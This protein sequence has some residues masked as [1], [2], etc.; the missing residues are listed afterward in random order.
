MASMG[1]SGGAPEVGA[2]C[3]YAGRPMTV[4]GT[5]GSNNTV[6]GGPAIFVLENPPAGASTVELTPGNTTTATLGGSVSVTGGGVLRGLT[7]AFGT[8][9]PASV[10]VP[11]CTVGGMVIDAVCNGATASAFTATG[12]GQTRRWQRAV[13][14][15]SAAGNGAGSTTP[16]VAGTTTVG[17]TI[18]PSDWNGAVAVEVLP[19]SPKGAVRI[20]ANNQGYRSNAGFP[21][22]AWTMICWFKINVDRNVINGIW[23]VLNAAKTIWTNLYTA[24][25]GTTVGIEDGGTYTT[26]DFGGHA[27]TVGTWYANAFSLSGTNANLYI[28]TNPASL[29]KYTTATMNALASPGDFYLGRDDGGTPYIDGCLAAVKFYGAELTPAEVAAELAQYAPV[30]TTNLNRWYPFVGGADV[31]DHSGNGNHLT[32][33]VAPAGIADGPPIPWGD[34]PAPPEGA[35]H[36]SAASLLRP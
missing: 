24:A 11:G 10:A 15:S 1:G 17:Y 7:K 25:D 29:T 22:G 4:V 30:R 12:T 26:T 19:A 21:T 2:S 23:A 36:S 18:A 13:N 20:T 5:Q 31:Y 6:N 27:T 16:S 14:G 33:G 9:S 34:V 35:R 3:T 8:A 32:V 28:G